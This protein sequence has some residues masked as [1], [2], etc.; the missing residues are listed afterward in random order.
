MLIPSNRHAAVSANAFA[1]LN[2]L[3]PGRIDFGV[4]TGFTGRRTMGV[5]AMKIADMEEYVRVTM[6]LLAEETVEANFEG[7][8]RRIRFLNPEAGCINTE[9]PVT[10]NISAYGPRGQ[11][12]T[13]ELGAR[14]I[15]FTGDVSSALEHLAG[16]Q[17]S[18]AACRR[19][20]EEL[21]ATNFALGCVLEADE[22]ADS[23]RA[24][25]QAGPRAAVQLHRAV[26]EAIQ[27]LPNAGRLPENLAEL[28]RRYVEAAENFEPEEVDRYLV[29]HRGHLMFVRPEEQPFITSELIRHT[30]WT[31]TD[32]E[33]IEAIGALDDAGYSQFTIQLV[34]GSE[35]AIEDWARI[36][37]AFE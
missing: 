4:G 3:A 21:Y 19:P 32:S 35:D 13:A 25:A 6:G 14:W 23:P 16:M 22:P 20:P 15:T 2:K 8:A 34:P 29:T 37:S 17:E 28:C 30:S 33:L 7:K 1:T 27:G 18:W 12:I 5:G 26:D 9:D 36:K 10:L 31:G 24:I 11:Q